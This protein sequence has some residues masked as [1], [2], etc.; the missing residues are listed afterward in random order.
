MKY[1][2]NS[3]EKYSYGV[4]TEDNYKRFREEIGLPTT[5]GPAEPT[6]SAL[7]SELD[8][9]STGEFAEIGKKIREDLSEPL[10]AELLRRNL[11]ELETQFGRFDE[12]R[13]IGVPEY[14]ET[15]YQDLTD[16]AWHID[17]HLTETGF[18]AGIEKHLPQFEPEYIE[19]T[20]KQLL[21][22][23]SLTETLANLEFPEDEQM[24]LVTNIVNS[25]SRLSWWGPAELYP[26]ADS[27]QES[28]EKVVPEYVSPLQKRAMSGSLLWI[29]GLDWRLWQHEVMLTDD[30]I[31]KGIWD[32]KSMLA[33]VY[34]MSDAARELAEGTISDENLT[35]L[36]TAST[37][38]MIIGQELVADDVARINDED[39]KPLEETDHENLSLGGDQ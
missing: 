24:S 22:D 25:S 39:R 16:A 32:V 18:F 36:L 31:E 13:R 30:I 26:T 19:T 34:L 38:I 28:E 35:T 11:S 14:G 15:P 23:E 1:G 10:D 12:L 5:E 29:D 8:M 4:V 33:G 37:A 7:R 6:L 17:D 20:T 27:K 9:V 3:R 2:N 21:T